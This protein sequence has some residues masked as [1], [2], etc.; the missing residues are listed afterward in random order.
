MRRCFRFSLRAGLIESRKGSVLVMVLWILVLMSFLTSQY[1]AHN[2]EKANISRNAWSSFR[3]RQAIV[4][5]T[6][7]FSTSAW[8][9]P[10]G[11]GA[12]GRWFRLYPDDIGV[13][14]RVDKE[15][16]RL[17]LN[18]GNEGEIKQKLSLMM[19]EKHQD[20]A[21]A[22][23]DAILDWRDPDDMARPHGAEAPAYAARGLNYR[24]ADGPFNAL[25]ELLLVIGVTP[26]LF[27]G[28][29]V[30]RIETDLTRRL[31]VTDTAVQKDTVPDALS[32]IFTIYSQ[33]GRRVSLLVPG[34]DNTYLYT[35]VILA[36]VSGGFN[37]V[38]RQ[39]VFGVADPETYDRLTELESQ[40]AK[41]E[42]RDRASR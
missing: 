18:S 38:D 6:Q 11:T 34:E 39:Q 26:N 37:V 40:V 4:S 36:N 5:L 8:P 23:S 1:V 28:D 22:V 32:E 20:E 2:R 21:D 9:V 31:M 41:Q 10:D 16:S 13:W 17:D 30:R 29:P 14:V 19:D 27:W 15:S 24:P 3:Q 12:N 35:N 33:T 7:L 25:S 42:S